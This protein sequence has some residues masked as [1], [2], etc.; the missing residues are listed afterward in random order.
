MTKFI[1][2]RHDADLVGMCEFRRVEPPRP[3]DD[4]PDRDEQTIA[5]LR[6]AEALDHDSRSFGTRLR[7]LQVGG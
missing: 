2:L 1:E 6:A 3:L 4:D 5:K 7:L